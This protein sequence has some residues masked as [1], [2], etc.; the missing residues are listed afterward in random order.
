M[1]ATEIAREQ[2]RSDV[3]FAAQPYSE[4]CRT[5]QSRPSRAGKCQDERTRSSQPKGTCAFCRPSE[6]SYQ[7]N[8]AANC[9]SLAGPAV[10][11]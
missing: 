2:K 7:R 8:F 11:I 9:S 6:I 1:A 3:G 10:V 5:Q 4:D